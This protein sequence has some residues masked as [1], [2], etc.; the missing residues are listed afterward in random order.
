[1]TIKVINLKKVLI[2]PYYLIL[3]SFFSGCSPGTTATSSTTTPQIVISPLAQSFVSVTS[4]TTATVSVATVPS[5]ES[6]VEVNLTSNNPLIMSASP[7]SCS[8]TA[9][10][11][12]CV[13][14]LTGE[15]VGATVFTA[16]AS[17]YSSATSTS[18]LVRPQFAY[19]TNYSN[20]VTECTVGESGLESAT[21]NTIEPSG[22]GALNV[23]LGI[24]VYAG[25]VYINNGAGHSYT[26]CNIGSAGFESNTC[27]TVVLPGESHP[28]ESG[29]TGIVINNN[30]VY[31]SNFLNATITECVVGNAG[32]ES[33]TCIEV[34]NLNIF[35]PYGLAVSNNIL[36]ITNASGD[37]LTK[38]STD[39]SP[40]ESSTCHRYNNIGEATDGGLTGM[41]IYKDHIYMASFDNDG[42]VRCRITESGMI[43]DTCQDILFDSHYLR[44]PIGVAINNGWIYIVNEGSRGTSDTGSYAQCRISESGYIFTD[45]CSKNIPSGAGELYLSQFIAID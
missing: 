3:L 41:A 14:T 31:I 29:P 12:S 7:E 8:L 36:Y 33:Q 1:M 43:P 16:A 30:I 15:S 18:L 32:I 44:F 11:N 20:T 17:G 10:S 24:A 40:I 5:A 6:V 26:Q 39:S 25:F 9:E 13:V 19:I 38:C 37:P 22:A 42:L 27:Q 34:P 2:F 4:S 45:T 28:T 35:D 21:C 23:P